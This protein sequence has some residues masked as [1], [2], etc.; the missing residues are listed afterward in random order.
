MALGILLLVGMAAFLASAFLDAP[1]W[2]AAAAIWMAA[3]L[4]WPRVDGTTRRLSAALLVAGGA[5]LALTLAGGGDV[6]PVAMMVINLPIVGLFIGVAFLS[7]VAAPAIEAEA[8]ER[9][10][11]ADDG[12]QVRAA[13]APGRDGLWST[14][15]AVHLFG[16]VINMSM[17]AI[18][19][20]RMA[21]GGTLGRTEATVLAR[22]YCGA[23]FWSPFFVAAA[24]AHTYAPD[25]DPFLTVPLGLLGASAALLLSAREVRAL[26]PDYRFPGFA[27][28]R[29]AML[30]TG[31][32]LV[33]VLIVKWLQPAMPMVVIVTAVTPPVALALLP[34]AAR[35]GAGMRL[36]RGTLPATSSQVVLFLAA[37]VFAY[38]LSG[39]LGQWM[40]GG[41]AS[42]TALAPWVYPLGVL[43]IV[44]AAYLGAHP[45]ISIAAVSSVLLPLGA[46][47]SLL[48]FVFVSGW[49]VGTAVAPLSGMNLFLIG[50][51]GLRAR[52]IA[53]WG[54]GY[55]VRMLA[56]VTALLSLGWG[57]RAL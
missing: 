17:A 2:P 43:V 26:G 57:L 19:G 54:M 31:T 45:V 29:R 55:A 50:R 11:P 47:H 35:V 38:G 52:D 12:T 25:A 10:A 56:V 9:S 51:Y 37:G 42:A 36:L 32:L 30:L 18:A 53:G 39:L 20:D 46:D 4:A 34:A 21:R 22:V 14:M 5:A 13:E 23:A 24:V 15:L 7:L 48:A 33:L 16:A 41:A 40:D 49:A 27:P 8:T 3:V 6:D 28:D 44:L 1:R